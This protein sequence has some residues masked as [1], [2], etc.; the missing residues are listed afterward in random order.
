MIAPIASWSP[1]GNV[2]WSSVKP[3]GGKWSPRQRWLSV[4][5][6]PITAAIGLRSSWETI[7][8]KSARNAESRRSSSTVVCSAS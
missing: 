8:T 3:G 7:E 4:F 2:M 6:D 1:S 5:A